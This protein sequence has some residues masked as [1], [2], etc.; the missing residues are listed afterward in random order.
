MQHTLPKGIDTRLGRSPA[1]FCCYVKRPAEL[2]RN[3]LDSS[4]VIRLTKEYA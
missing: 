1:A 2:L 4:P 3:T